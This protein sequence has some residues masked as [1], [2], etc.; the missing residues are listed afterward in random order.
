MRVR[1]LRSNRNCFAVPSGG[2]HGDEYGV[3]CLSAGPSQ[4][5]AV[6]V[7]FMALYPSLG[8]RSVIS[9]LEIAVPNLKELVSPENARDSDFVPSEHRQNLPRGVV[10]ISLW[11]CHRIPP[12]L[13]GTIRSGPRAGRSSLRYPRCYREL[14]WFPDGGDGASSSCLWTGPSRV[15]DGPARATGRAS[16][17]CNR[18]TRPA[19][20][21]LRSAFADVGPTSGHKRPVM[22]GI[23]LGCR[24]GG[25]PGQ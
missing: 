25:S 22:I 10:T 3:E 12:F 8:N 16:P 15:D 4:D 19:K 24:C 21:S 1:E 23:W 20:T 17:S 9:A 11:N 18:G 6:P 14:R 2:G 7:P 5:I 13:R